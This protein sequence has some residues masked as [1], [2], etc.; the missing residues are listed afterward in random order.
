MLFWGQPRLQIIPSD[1]AS[2]IM[3]EAKAK[4]MR[5]IKLHPRKWYYLRRGKFGR[6][7]R[8]SYSKF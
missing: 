8:N 6:S 5:F 4:K 1:E 3:R 2:R 7:I